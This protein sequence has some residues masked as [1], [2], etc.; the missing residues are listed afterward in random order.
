MKESTPMKWK[1]PKARIPLAT[2]VKLEMKLDSQTMLV[3]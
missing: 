1:H 3:V 2:D